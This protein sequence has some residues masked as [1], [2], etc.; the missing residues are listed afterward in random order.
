MSDQINVFSDYVDFN[1]Q[2]NT[3]QRL[4]VLYKNNVSSEL[5]KGDLS[6]LTW[7]E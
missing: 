7:Y 5:I 2:H 4:E 3:A 1:I 6:P